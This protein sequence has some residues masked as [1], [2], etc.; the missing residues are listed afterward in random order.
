MQYENGQAHARQALDE[1]FESQNRL[2]KAVAFFCKSTSFCSNP[3][4]YEWKYIAKREVL[5]PCDHNAAALNDKGDDTQRNYPDA[6]VIRWEKHFVRI[7]EGTLHRGESN[8]LALR[9]FYID[10]RSWM[11]LMGEGYDHA[12]ALVNYYMRYKAANTD[13]PA[14]GRWYAIA[15][16]PPK[17]I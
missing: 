8:L 17:S 15:E 3:A 12:G 4:E 10:E 5:V 11:I 1:A 13:K 2:A 16:I 9:R 7:V 6:G 14:E